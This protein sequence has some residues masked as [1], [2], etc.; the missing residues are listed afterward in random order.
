VTAFGAVRVDAVKTS[1]NFAGRYHFAAV[2]P[3]KERLDVELV[4]ARPLASPRVV[5]SQALGPE[6]H[7][8][9]IQVRGPEDLDAELI[10]W[11]REA[12]SLRA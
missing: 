12:H 3:R 1:I 11:L 10:E 5:R 4:L 7:V 9:W 6:K 2:W 8:H